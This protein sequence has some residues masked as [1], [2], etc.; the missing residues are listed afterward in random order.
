MIK[1]NAGYD[2]KHLFIGSE[3]TL[4]VVTRVVLR[5]TERP[6]GQAAA[7]VPVRE[8]GSVTT[9]LRRLGGLLGGSLSAFEVMWEEFYRLVT[10]PPARGVVIPKAIRRS[11]LG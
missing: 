6:L 11:P 10:T 8:F 7:L 5:L 1:N 2:L 9:L 3:G 4:G